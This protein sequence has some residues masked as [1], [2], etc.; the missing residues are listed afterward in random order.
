M[1]GAREVRRDRCWV[2]AMSDRDAKVL[3]YVAVKLGAP[4]VLCVSDSCVVAGSE[5][6]M[7][8]HILTLSH[9]AHGKYQIT[10]ARYGHVLKVMKLG[11]V[12]SFDEES[13]ARFHPLAREDGMEVVDFTPEH[14]KKPAGPAIPLIRVQWRAK[15]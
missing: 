5:S 3:G 11:G 13:Y 1:K 15:R 14:E 2:N 8:E 7:K 9:N 12:Y 4:D 6:K 10:K